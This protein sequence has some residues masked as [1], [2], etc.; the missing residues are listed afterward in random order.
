MSHDDKINE[1]VGSLRKAARNLKAAEEYLTK[2]DLADEQ[3]QR[4]NDAL[5]DVV[6]QAK[7]LDDTIFESGDLDESKRVEFPFLLEEKPL[8]QFDT[9]RLGSAPQT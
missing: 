2:H 7:S 3:A 5:R 8:P 1:L 6:L 9:A 4:L